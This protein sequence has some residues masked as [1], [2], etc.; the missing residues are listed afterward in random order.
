M[1][2]ATTSGQFSLKNATIGLPFFLLLGAY[3]VYGYFREWYIVSDMDLQYR[4]L[5]GRGGYFNWS[6]VVRVRCNPFGSVTLTTASGRRVRISESLWGFREFVRLLLAH[7]PRE[8][9]GDWSYK[10]LKGTG[11]E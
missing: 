5:F 11:S 9:I 8:K 3:G 10:M 1:V 7:V 6:E 4:P 2:G